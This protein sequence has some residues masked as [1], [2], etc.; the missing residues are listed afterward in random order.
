MLTPN[1][2]LQ[3]DQAYFNGAYVLSLP[4]FVWFK[5]ND[6]SAKPRTG[7][8]CELAGK[9][10]MI[11]IGGLDPAATQTVAFLPPDTNPQGLGIFDMVQM[12]WTNQFDA[13]ADPYTLPDPIKAWYS[14][15]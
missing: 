3:A 14:D 10:Q 9:R 12:K 8:T 13:N 7:H 4:G 5:A 6:T 1:T 15:P 11:S 2:T